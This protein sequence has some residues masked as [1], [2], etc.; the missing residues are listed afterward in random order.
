MTDHKDGDI[1]SKLEKAAAFIIETGARETTSGH[2][3]IYAEEI[4]PEIL[5]PEQ[6]KQ[7]LDG[8]IGILQEYE[9]IGD[10][11]VMDDGTVDMIVYLEYCPNY[12]P[13]A[14]EREE[15]LYPD[16]REILDPLTT[17]RRPETLESAIVD[18]SAKPTLAERLEEGKR[19]AAQHEKPDN[20]N[21]ITKQGERE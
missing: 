7:N 3:Y 5:T 8:I 19:R 4:P 21:K 18:T 17:R 20:T 9:A 11:E 10:I 12:E 14:D 2:Y 6:Y 16:D 1:Q 13:D 15:G